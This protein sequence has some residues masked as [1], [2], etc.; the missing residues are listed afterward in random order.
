VICGDNILCMSNFRSKYHKLKYGTDL[1]LGDM[2]P[3]SFD[4]DAKGLLPLAFLFI[5]DGL[6]LSSR[7]DDISRKFFVGSTV[8]SFV[9]ITFQ[10]H[11]RTICHLKAQNL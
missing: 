4:R 9:F 11:K 10:H 2:T 1:D 5:R 3:P 7:R 8:S 6:N